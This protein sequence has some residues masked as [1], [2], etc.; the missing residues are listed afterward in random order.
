MPGLVAAGMRNGEIAERLVL[1]ERTV[2][3]H[4]TNI[5]QKLGLRN[6]AEATA[7]AIREQLG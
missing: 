2:S 7:L 5:Y 4:L 1:S 6:R 3:R